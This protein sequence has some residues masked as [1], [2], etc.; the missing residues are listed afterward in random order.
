MIRFSERPMGII[1]LILPASITIVPEQSKDSSTRRKFFK[2][3]K[4]N[5]WEI[6]SLKAGENQRFVASNAISIAQSKVEPYLLPLA[7]Y[8]DDTAVGFLLHGIVPDDGHYWIV[9]L[10]VDEKHQKN[11]YGK[12]AMELII[13]KIKEDTDHNKVFIST[14]PENTIGLNLYKRLGFVSTGRIEDGE[15]ILVLEWGITK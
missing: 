15:E 9:R 12:K 3:T 7:I 5:F 1:S 4:E 11:G 14:S 10:M 8:D 2:I 13:G 6:I